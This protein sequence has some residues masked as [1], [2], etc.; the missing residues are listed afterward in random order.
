VTTAVTNPDTARG[1]LALVGS[2]GPTVVGTELAFATDTP[3]ELKLILWVLHTGVRAQILGKKW[4]GCDGKTGRVC[5]LDPGKA[6]PD[7]IT[8]LCVEGD[9][10]WDRINPVA[11]REYPKLFAHW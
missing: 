9:A 10:R 4:Y 7:G 1:L 6:L 11:R 3:T 2:F 5:E 8:L